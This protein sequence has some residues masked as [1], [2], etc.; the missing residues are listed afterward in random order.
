MAT[1]SVI[2]PVFNAEKYISTCIESL[3]SQSYSDFEIICVDDGSTDNSPRI[4][5][6]YMS[7]DPRIKIIEQKNQFA[8]NARNTGMEVAS[9]KYC[10]FLNK[11]GR[12]DH[13]PS[14]RGF[15]KKYM[16]FYLFSVK[17]NMRNI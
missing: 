8:G 7:M 6:Q 4:L 12:Y 3:I 1:V 2:I 17:W 10:M 15:D 9:G 5:Q 14:S 16:I 11:C 13:I